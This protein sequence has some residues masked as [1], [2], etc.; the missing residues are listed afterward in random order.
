MQITVSI[1]EDNEQLRTTLARVINRADGFKCVSDYSNAEDAL[2]ELEGIVQQLE[3]GQVKLDEAITAYQ[4]DPNKNATTCPGFNYGSGNVTAPDLCWVRRPN[5]KVGPGPATPPAAAA[6]RRIPRC[7]LGARCVTRSVSRITI[8][9]STLATC[10][11]K[12]VT[13]LST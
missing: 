2:K 9:F 10:C 13:S 11:Q 12:R 6:L 3:R 1:V 8:P 5:A 7:K 4:S